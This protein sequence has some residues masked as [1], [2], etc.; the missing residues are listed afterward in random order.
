MV[1]RNYSEL[2]DVYPV[3]RET[4]ERL[5][6]FVGLFGK[7]SKAINLAAPSTLPA[8]WRRH[9]ADSLQI[10]ALN[11][12][13]QRWV[14]LG[15]GGGFPG[16]VTAIVLLETEGGHV[17]LIESNQKKAAFLRTVLT[18]TGARGTVH[19][20]RIEDAAR[21]LS[22]QTAVSAR[23]VA[24]LGRLIQLAW[25]WLETGATAWFHKGRDYRAEI[26]NARRSWAFDLLEHP[27]KVDET[28]V[29]L[30]IDR[31]S[32]KNAEDAGLV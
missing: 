23:A 24:D 17:D 21:R 27:S 31:A 13:P 3:S 2:A 1:H 30:Q 10:Y 19:A 14:D 11:P 25:P 22:G 16:V 4:M 15:S 20:I 6:L 28:S 18:E 7:W 12:G 8:I 26:E 29:V 9:V 5:E 32:R